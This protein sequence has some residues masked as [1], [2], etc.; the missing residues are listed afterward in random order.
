M[1]WIPKILA[2]FLFEDVVRSLKRKV[3]VPLCVT[4]R[5][6]KAVCSLIVFSLVPKD[7][8]RHFS[9]FGGVKEGKEHWSL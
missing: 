1:Q 9:A 8:A 7:L 6:C 4:S 5:T 2:Y 3:C